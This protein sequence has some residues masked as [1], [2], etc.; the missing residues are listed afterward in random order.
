MS[1]GLAKIDSVRLSAAPRMAD[2]AKWGFAIADACG[3]KPEAFLKAYRENRA[4]ANEASLENSTLATE[5]VRLMESTSWW[6]GTAGELLDELRGNTSEETRKTHE[7]PKS[8]RVLGAELR[9][10]A[11]VLRAAGIEVTIHGPSNSRRLVTLSK[12]TSQDKG[13]SEEVY[14]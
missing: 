8:P 6:Q 10:V 5:I 12:S 1:K 3:W 9:I 11:P 14:V 13:P 4:R 7:W 2:F